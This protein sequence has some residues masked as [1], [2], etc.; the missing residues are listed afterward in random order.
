MLSVAAGS[1]AI[2]TCWRKRLSCTWDA[3]SS[4]TEHLLRGAGQAEP[5]RL[6]SKIMKSTAEDHEEAGSASR[7]LR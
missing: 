7:A 2:P 4:L 1:L 5:G 6:A 3:I